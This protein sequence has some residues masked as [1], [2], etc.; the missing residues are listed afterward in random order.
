MTSI[1]EVVVVGSGG[2][3]RRYISNLKILFPEVNINCLPLSNNSSIVNFLGINGVLSSVDEAIGKNP[4]YAII[5]TPSVS[6]LSYAAEFLK[7]NIPVLIEKPLTTSLGELD[8]FKEILLDKSHLIEVAYCLRFL[9]AAIKLKEILNKETLGDI[10]SA[11]V[12]V[13]QFLPDWRPEIDYK[14]SVSANKSLGGGVLLELS[15]EL[16]YLTWLFGPINSVFCNLTN[17]NSLEIDVEDRVDAIL[18][19]KNVLINLHMDFLQRHPTRT[20]KIIGSKGNL[21]WDIIENKILIERPKGVLDVVYSEPDYDKNDM[22]LDMIRSF[23][24]LI[25]KELKPLVGVEQSSHVV[26]LIDA[27]RTS[28]K[29]SKVIKVS[30]IINK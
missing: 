27:M 21:V 18:Q 2:M 26:S 7:K 1:K 12:E 8:V 16:D 17:T 29:F 24:K 20:C 5:A 9:P 3:A 25:T 11:L 19:N 22:Y 28:S 13:G 10:H 4:D 6:H 23:N 14:L 30:N 15:H